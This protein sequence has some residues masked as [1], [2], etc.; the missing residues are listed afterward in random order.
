MVPLRS[1][2]WTGKILHFPNGTLTGV[3]EDAASIQF[4]NDYAYFTD[5]EYADFAL[6][7]MKIMAENG[8]TTI[9]DAGA[10][11]YEPAAFKANLDA[12]TILTRSHFCQALA[13]AYMQED[14]KGFIRNVSEAMND[15]THD[16]KSATKP[17]IVWKHF[18]ALMD[19]IASAPG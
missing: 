5:Q 18:K 1:L 8:I 17:S 2:P 11:L 7:A 4:F 16:F 19:G 3:F 13:P 6:A 10:A 15:W 9:M 12:D 14:L